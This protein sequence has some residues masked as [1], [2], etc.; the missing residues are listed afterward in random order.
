[1]N[2]RIR[3]RLTTIPYIILSIV[4][5]LC[6]VALPKADT[7]ITMYH[8][9]TIWELPSIP[10]SKIDI[11]LWALVVAKEYDHSLDIQHYLYVLDSCIAQIRLML[12]GRTSDGDMF[13][14]TRMF[15]CTP[16]GWNNYHPFSY[17]LDDPFGDK[18]RHQLLS[19]YLDTH[20]GNCISMPTLFYALMQ[21]LDPTIPVCAVSAP[22][23]LFCR[24]RD[25]QTGDIWNFEATNGTTAR[26]IWMIQSLSISI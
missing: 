10:D 6:G 7:P 5:S 26:N 9:Q 12:W 25:R 1:M 19:T 21:R 11:G 18:V 24:V 20:K 8:G 23:H 17:D 2:S 22:L 13:A 15:I 16:G 3:F 14:A 4:L